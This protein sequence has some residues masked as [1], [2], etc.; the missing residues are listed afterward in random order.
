[1]AESGPRRKLAAILAADVVGFST[2]KPAMDSA[3]ALLRD[4]PVRVC[5]TQAARVNSSRCNDSGLVV[6]VVPVPHPLA[7]VLELA[8]RVHPPS[9]REGATVNPNR[10]SH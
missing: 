8:V 1:M 10:E 4:T 6:G 2:L 9:V 3:G 7:P 5:T